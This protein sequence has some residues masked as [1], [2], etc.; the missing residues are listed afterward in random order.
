MLNE[1]LFHSNFQLVTQ[2]LP[3]EAMQIKSSLVAQKVKTACGA[4][5]LGLIPGLGRFPGEGNGYPF[6]YSCLKNSMDR[7]A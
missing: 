1:N 2:V 5:D 7:G 4:R 6:Q 3:S